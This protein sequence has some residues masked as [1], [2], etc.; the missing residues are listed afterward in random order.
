ML[1]ARHGKDDLCPPLNRLGKCIIGCL[2]TGMKCHDHIHLR[3]AVIICDVPLQEMQF[4]I[5]IFLRESAAFLNYICLEIQ[6][7]DVD[8]ITLKFSQIIIHG[9]SKIR[10]TAAKIQN[11]DLPLSGKCRKDILDKFQKTVDL[12]KFVIRVLV[13]FAL[14]IHYAEIHQKWDW[15]S[16]FEDILLYPVVCHD[17]HRFQCR[18]LFYFHGL[19]TLLA[20]KNGSIFALSLYLKLGKTVFEAVCNVGS[21]FLMCVV[22]VDGFLTDCRSCLITDSSFDLH[23][24]Y[25]HFGR[26]IGI[27]FALSA[28]DRQHHFLVKLFLQKFL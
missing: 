16:F 23:R 4:L 14:R 5:T 7:D 21:H 8:I 10:L 13:D 17:L 26:D 24:T 28:Q 15:Y 2:V 20:D 1:A 3:N 18:M 27:F 11:R 9:K 22:L 6:T 19:F 12:F 25:T